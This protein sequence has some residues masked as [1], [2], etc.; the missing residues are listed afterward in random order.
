MWPAQLGSWAP[1]ATGN[2]LLLRHT[3]LFR[4]QIANFSICYNKALVEQ[5]EK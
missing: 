2:L 1:D 3:P 5:G 4:S